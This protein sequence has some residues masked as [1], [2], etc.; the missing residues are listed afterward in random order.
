MT[1]EELIKILKHYPKD[2][3]VQIN[4]RHHNFGSENI[5][6]IKMEDEHN[7]TFPNLKGKLYIDL[8]GGDDA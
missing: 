4:S 7:N 6:S 5:G 3:I 8:I 1:N 2:A